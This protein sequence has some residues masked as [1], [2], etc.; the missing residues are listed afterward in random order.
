[1]LLANLDPWAFPLLVASIGILML[2]FPNLFIALAD[3]KASFGGYEPVK[4]HP[5]RSPWM[6]RAFGLFMLF[7]AWF[8]WTLN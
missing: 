7:F 5:M 8:A 4:G 1:M 3:F 6:Y 2:V